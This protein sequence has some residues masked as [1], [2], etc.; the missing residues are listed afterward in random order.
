[1]RYALEQRQYYSVYPALLLEYHPF[2]KVDKKRIQKPH[3]Q[4][5]KNTITTLKTLIN[6]THW[7]PFHF[8]ALYF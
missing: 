4:L 2:Y 5:F 1:M 6:I 3:Y 7:F 8:D